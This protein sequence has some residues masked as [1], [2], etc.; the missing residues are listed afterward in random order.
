MVEVNITVV[1]QLAN[2]S[3]YGVTTELQAS[4]GVVKSVFKIQIK[5]FYDNLTTCNLLIY[6]K[7]TREMQ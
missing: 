3:N 5:S 2:Y 1:D 4:Y 6:N 7:A